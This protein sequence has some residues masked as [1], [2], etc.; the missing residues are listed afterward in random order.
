VVGLCVLCDVFVRVC[1]FRCG[2]CVRV[3]V[4]V[5]VCV[6]VCVCAHVAGLCVLCEV[7]RVCIV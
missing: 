1:V 2:I 6:W 3:R 5:S 7:M 4:C